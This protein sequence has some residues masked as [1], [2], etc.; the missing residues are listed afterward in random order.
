MK[1]FIYITIACVGLFSC[2]NKSNEEGAAAPVVSETTVT[3]SQEQQ[4][5][6]ELE[7]NMLQIKQ[8]FSHLSVKGQISTPPESKVTIN[9]PMGGYVKKT[10]LMNG[11]KVKKGELLAVIEDAAFLQLQQDYLMGKNK[12]ILLQSEL[13]RQEELSRSQ[14]SSKKQFELART[15]R[16]NQR[17]YVKALEEKIKLIGLQPANI[18]AENITSSVS[19]VS[20]ING[21]ITEVFINV[22]KHI[23]ENQPIA[24]IADFSNLYLSL[25]VFEKELDFISIGQPIIAYTNANREKKYSGKVELIGKAFKEDRSVEVLCRLDNQYPELIPGLFMNADIEI[26]TAQTAAVPIHEVITETQNHFVFIQKDTHVFELT[27]VKVIWKSDTEMGITHTDGS[28]VKEKVV[29][30]NAYTLY[31]QLRNKAD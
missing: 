7:V 8:G 5:N 15:E 13:E 21:Y 19:V 26:Q 25:R 23:S 29:T 20:P 17:I 22:G 9:F 6:A 12:L 10:N 18:S 24:E 28:A 1:N 16:D 2:G 27:P 3:L 11:S 4:H 14:A 30:R 31:M